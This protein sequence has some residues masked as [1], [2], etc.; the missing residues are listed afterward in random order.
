MALELE[1]LETKGEKARGRL[2]HT[3]EPVNIASKK[4]PD[5]GLVKLTQALRR[6]KEVIFGVCAVVTTLG[7]LTSFQMTPYYTAE[8]LVMVNVR[9]TNII[10]LHSV[11]SG[12]PPE[13]SAV[14]SEVDILRGSCKI[15]SRMHGDD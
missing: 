11:M 7:I 2:P 15:K 6:R 5:A 13:N 9:K 4:N 14:R 1:P 8:S 12:L 3:D 10:D